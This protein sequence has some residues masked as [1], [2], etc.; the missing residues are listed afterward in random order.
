MVGPA[1]N[2]PIHYCH[3]IT[4]SALMAGI[5]GAGLDREHGMHLQGQERDCL[6]GRLEQTAGGA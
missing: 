4:G 5:Q 1:G 3:Y 2:S 6:T